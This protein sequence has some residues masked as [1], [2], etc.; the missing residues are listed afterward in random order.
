MPAHAEAVDAPDLT[1]FDV[2][3]TSD[4]GLLD[5]TA[6]VVERVARPRTTYAYQVRDHTLWRTT[7]PRPIFTLATRS[8]GALVTGHATNRF[9]TQVTFD[10]EPSALVCFTMLQ[11]GRIALL[12]S[13]GETNGTAGCGLLFR[14]GPAARL[15]M[16]DDTARTNIFLDAGALEAALAR[17]LERPLPRPLVFRPGVDWSTGAAAS[18]KRQ[19][20]FL[21]HE[22][23]RPDGIASNPLA[24]ASMTD[25]LMSLTLTAASHNYSGQIIEALEARR[26]TAV[27]PAYVRRAEDF[28][29][30]YCTQPIRIAEI[31]AAAGCSVRTLGA[32][33]RRFRGT[34]PLQSL[35]TIRL[36]QA[37]AVLEH[38]EAG[39][40]VA[41]IAR[42]YGFT[43][44]GRFKAAYQH[45]F[46]Q[47]PM[48]TQRHGAR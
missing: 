33:F 19:L 20:D 4:C 15:L 29:A 39:V 46:G 48:E 35:H 44:A 31:A 2:S 1:L 45:L 22:F 12:D 5:G 43:N 27:V 25:L 14:P 30:S 28:M 10:G 21:V 41:Q 37:R 6:R 40:T 32:A 24:L 3:A 18:L 16:S 9:A 34:T 36:R 26:G 11:H 17:I 42:R 8:A 38:G 13:E 23:R 7:F 47:T